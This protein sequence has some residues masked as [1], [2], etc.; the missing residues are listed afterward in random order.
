MELLKNL[1]VS[2]LP[3]PPAWMAGVPLIG[4]RLIGW[5]YSTDQQ[6]VAMFS[7]LKPYMGE[8]GNWLLARSAK[9]GA[10]IFELVLS[11]MLIFFFYRDGLRLQAFAHGM[12]QRLIGDTAQQYMDI[13]A[14]TVQRVVNGV[15][16]TAAAQGLLAWTV[17]FLIAGV[18]GPLVLGLLTFVCSL[19]MVPPLIWGPAT[20][21]A[22]LP[23]RAMAMAFS[24]AMWGFFMISGVDNILKPYLISRGGNLPLVVVLLGVLGGLLSVR[25]HR[26]VPRAGAAGGGLQPDQRLDR[27]L[28]PAAV[29]ACSLMVRSR[30]LPSP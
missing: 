15:I 24:S 17:G 16:G 22:V 12:L 25:L 8:V 27:E 19:L 6:G 30:V 29:T 9:L 2:G 11:L 3:P 1:Q 10:G 23:G 13:I 7:A 14:G 28:A 4:D 20:A 21:L 5:W 18:P 26:F